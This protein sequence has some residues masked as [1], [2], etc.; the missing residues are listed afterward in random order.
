MGFYSVIK[1]KV[2]KIYYLFKYIFGFNFLIFVLDI[3]FLC[4]HGTVKLKAIL[5]ML[6]DLGAKIIL[7]SQDEQECMLGTAV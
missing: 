4:L 6:S 5:N 2:A 3:L 7:V 1:L